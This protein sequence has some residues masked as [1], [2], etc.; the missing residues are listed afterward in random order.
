MVRRVGEESN[1]SCS[2]GAG[3]N[4]MCESESLS[5]RTRC[6]VLY[7]SHASVPSLKDHPHHCC[8][9]VVQPLGYAAGEPLGCPFVTISEY[10]HLPG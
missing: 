4:V 9:A 1:C 5:E 3:S 10:P 7:V 8:G 6:F 2:Q